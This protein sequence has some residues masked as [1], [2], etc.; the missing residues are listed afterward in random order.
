M[1]EPWYAHCRALDTLSNCILCVSLSDMDPLS[2]HCATYGF[3]PT[4]YHKS[5]EVDT[6][7]KVRAQGIVGVVDCRAQDGSFQCVPGFHLLNEAW[8]EAAERK[9]IK[10]KIHKHRYQLDKEDSL[11]QFVSKCLIGAHECVWSIVGR[12]ECVWSVLTILTVIV[13]LEAL[14]TFGE[15]VRRDR[16]HDFH[17]LRDVYQCAYIACI[18]QLVACVFVTDVR[19]S[20]G[21]ASAPAESLF[22]RPLGVVND[23]TMFYLLHFLKLQWQRIP[24]CLVQHD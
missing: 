1:A 4:E 14:S 19:T 5:A 23:R 24:P 16:Y 11:Q 22:G 13:V 9:R 3:N 2:Q 21:S 6:F 20:A 17:N 7:A 10:G 8:V 12:T 18:E 15:Q